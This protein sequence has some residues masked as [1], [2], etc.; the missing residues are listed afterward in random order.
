ML[1]PGELR[2]HLAERYGFRADTLFT[3]DEDVVLLRRE[4]GASWVARVFGP[5]PRAAVEGAAAVLR[6]L[7]TQGSAVP[8]RGVSS[9]AR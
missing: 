3:F 7:E 4:D 2:S 1:E 5:Q 8:A 6:W 9:A